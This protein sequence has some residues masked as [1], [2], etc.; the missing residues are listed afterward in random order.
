MI[1]NNGK[2]R[3]DCNS[4]C[5]A[6][7]RLRIGLQNLPGFFVTE[8]GTDK[9]RLADR[10]CA[11]HGTIL[12]L[13]Q[14]SISKARSNQ[15]TEIGRI[16]VLPA[17]RMLVLFTQVEWTPD[18]RIGRRGCAV[19]S[20]TMYPLRTEPATPR[21]RCAPA[22]GVPPAKLSR[23]ART[24][25]QQSATLPGLLVLRGTDFRLARVQVFGV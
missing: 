9:E 19:A 24:S 4:V 12:T 13:I 11:N 18:G 21:A 7:D 16:R 3:A 23:Y 20:D 22:E 10:E 2:T 8:I 15:G 1:V 14:S 25:L 6:P 5:I 17:A